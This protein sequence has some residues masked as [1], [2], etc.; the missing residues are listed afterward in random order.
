MNNSDQPDQPD[1][2]DLVDEP[3]KEHDDDYLA[4]PWE[5]DEVELANL[6]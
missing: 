3:E 6:A 1:L 5:H 2:F 4:Y